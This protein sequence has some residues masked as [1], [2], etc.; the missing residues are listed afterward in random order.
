M[1][2]VTVVCL[3]IPLV[4]LMPFIDLG[5]LL[6]GLVAL[7]CCRVLFIGLI[8]RGVLLVIGV[9]WAL[10]PVLFRWGSYTWTYNQVNI[11]VWLCLRNHS[12]TTIISRT[13][14]CGNIPSTCNCD[15]STSIL[16]FTTATLR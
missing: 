14:G 11:G 13:I 6:V 16:T 8:C 7:A 12:T 2:G 10:T 4:A 3:C 5:V 1:F 15:I 9:V